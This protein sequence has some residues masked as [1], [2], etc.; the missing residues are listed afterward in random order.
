MK[1]K[2]HPDLAKD[3]KLKEVHNISLDDYKR[4]LKEQ[5]GVCAICGDQN[6]R[7]DPRTGKRM[8][9]SVDHDHTC[10]PKKYSCGDCFRGL[11]CNR[12]NMGLG[13]FNDDPQLMFRAISYLT[14]LL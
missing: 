6:G 1:R 8:M 4:V 10:C 9:L 14:R 3:M 2:T 12:C 7:V 11:L 5:G 13:H